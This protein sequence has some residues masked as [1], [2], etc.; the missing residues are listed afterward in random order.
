MT[1]Q[2]LNRLADQR[3]TVN[4]EEIEAS[5]IRLGTTPTDDGLVDERIADA[6]ES[7]DPIGS[8]GDE[9]WQSQDLKTEG[10][11]GKALEEIERRIGALKDAYPFSLSKGTL[12]YKATQN[13]LYEFLL[14]VSLAENFTGPKFTRLPRLFERLVARLVALG[15]GQD[16][17]HAHVGCPRDPNTKFKEAMVGL[18]AASGEWKWGPE[19]HLDPSR[20]KDEGLDYVVWPKARDHRS[21]S[22]IF[23]I[24]QCDGGNDWHTKFD[25]LNEKKLLKWFK[26]ATT[27]NPIRTFAIPFHVV[28]SLL[29]EASQEAGYI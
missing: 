14:A 22:Q 18:H 24:G 27:V 10:T 26:H 28:D 20:A 13:G 15:F 9:R 17:N 2:F 25:D 21:I 6:F 11:T 29:R 12:R 23:V 1:N 4:A 19:D 8:A 5:A 7:F 16:C 3:A